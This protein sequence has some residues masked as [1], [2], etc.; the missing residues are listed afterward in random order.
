MS[1]S[2]SLMCPCC[3]ID[4]LSKNIRY[5]NCL[6]RSCQILAKINP[7]RPFQT[8]QAC[9]THPFTISG[10]TSSLSPHICCSRIYNIV[11]V[12][13]LLYVKINLNV[14]YHSVKL[15]QFTE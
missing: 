3:I 11:T 10:L 1:T 4:T 9:S 14:I 5:S 6:M 15:M 7:F 8:V 12:H 2:L 13:Q